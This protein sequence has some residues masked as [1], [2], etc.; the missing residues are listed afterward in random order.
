M[1]NGDIRLIQDRAEL[2]DHVSCMSGRELRVM[3]VLAYVLRRLRMFSSAAQ[4]SRSSSL[5]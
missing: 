2:R 1:T 4:T 3:L 5:R